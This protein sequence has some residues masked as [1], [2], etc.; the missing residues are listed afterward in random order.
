MTSFPLF[1]VT[2]VVVCLTIT[3][4]IQGQEPGGVAQAFDQARERYQ[5]Q[6]TATTTSMK[7][8]YLERLRMLEEK[9]AGE[10][11]YESAQAYFEEAAR[12]REDLGEAADAPLTLTLLPYEAELSGGVV[13]STSGTI[14]S[15][16]GW[17]PEAS[18]VWKLPGIPRGGYSVV[19]F[20]GNNPLPVPVTLSGPNYFVAGEL[21]SAK[22]QEVAE[23]SLGNLR[24]I[25]DLPALTLSID[26]IA[27]PL[28]LEIQQI[29]L[30]SHAP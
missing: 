29:V 23:S 27:A 12:V 8:L 17:G 18:A 10:G 14:G 25:G 7:R 11:D 2:L 28:E 9:A 26:E 1:T 4:A 19:V 22:D 16:T 5:E 30:I 3:G 20:H 13:L 15:L 21:V 24:I 6:V